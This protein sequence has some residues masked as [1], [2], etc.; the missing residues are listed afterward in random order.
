MSGNGLPK[1]PSESANGADPLRLRVEKLVY[2]GDGL[3]HDPDGNAVSVPFS[4]PGELIELRTLPLNMPRGEREGVEDALH[5][6]EPSADRVAPRCVHFGRCGG[7]QLQMAAYPA[8]LRAKAE[9]L[10][11]L[12]GGAGLRDLP[13]LE[14]LGSP[15]PYGYRN[16]I[17]LRARRGEGDGRLNLGYSRRGT[18]E[19]LPVS[20]CPI[21]APVLWR[22]AEAVMALAAKQGDRALREADVWLEAAAEVEFFCTADEARVQVTLLCPGKSPRDGASFARMA[23]A[24][25]KLL[26]ELSG[27]GAVRVDA[28][29]GRVIETVA[30]WGA[31]GLP[32][33]VNDELYWVSRGGFFQVNRFLLPTLV[34]LVCDEHAG[35]L[36][37]DLFAGVGLF[38]RVLARRFAA[39]TA[40]EQHPG[41]SLDLRGALRKL[42]PQHRTVEATTLDFLRRAVLER[43]RPEL[44]VLDPPRAGAGVEACQLLARLA[45]RQIAYLSCDPTTLARDLLVLTQSGY[46]IRTLHLIDLFPQ[47]YHLETLAVLHRTV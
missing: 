20:M 10:R 38:S 18:R 1:L 36:A 7:C 26:P 13:E 8:Q 4:L 3:A 2:G 23:E 30:A 24:L 35:G 27:C 5:L 28:Q 29:S 33:P 6:V 31:G 34:D 22:A 39:V 41:A 46:G 37:W 19:F 45:P 47:T 15:A 12:L 32:Y 43:E 14:M 42:G 17:R 44:V 16:R 40:V 9:I 25:Q 21:A 11:D